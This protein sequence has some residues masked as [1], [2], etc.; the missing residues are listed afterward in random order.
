MAGKNTASSGIHPSRQ[1]VIVQDFKLSQDAEGSLSD[2]L[3]RKLKSAEIEKISDVMTTFKSMR[4]MHFDGIASRQDMKRTLA[5]IAKSTPTEA[6]EALANCDEFTRAE[7]QRSLWVDM[8]E[9]SNITAE[10]IPSAASIA[11]QRME[12]QKLAGGAPSKGYQ[13]ML[14]ET[15]ISLWRQ[16]G[17]KSMALWRKDESGE[18]SPL[19]AWSAAMFSALEGTAFDWKK[20]WTL[21]SAE[22]QQG[23]VSTL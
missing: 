14:A 6:S 19:L 18:L 13:A 9:R 10:M 8:H 22:I 4:E 7:I 16:F 5:Y 21:L 17:G 20:T 2:A 15:C 11:L 1:G 12:S 3:G 23:K